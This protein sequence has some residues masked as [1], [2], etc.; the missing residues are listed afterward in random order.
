MDVVKCSFKT[1]KANYIY[2]CSKLKPDAYPVC[3]WKN[4]LEISNCP[5]DLVWNGCKSNCDYCDDSCESNTFASGCFCPE[6][7]EFKDGKCKKIQCVT[8]K[9]CECP[10]GKEFFCSSSEIISGRDHRTTRIRRAGRSKRSYRSLL[11][12]DP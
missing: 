2:E 1:I 11:P 10:E 4:E 3:E 5:G 8:N 7:S 6:G 12:V 9:L